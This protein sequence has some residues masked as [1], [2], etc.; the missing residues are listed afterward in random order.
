M[1]REYLIGVDVTFSKIEAGLVDLNGKVIKKI[2]LP[3]EAKRGKAKV[4]E[5][6][7]TA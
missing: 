6:I 2:L 3:T 5:N 7:V 1:D 4:I